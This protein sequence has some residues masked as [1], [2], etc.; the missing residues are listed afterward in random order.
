MVTMTRV[1]FPEN[2]PDEAILYSV[3]VAR[4]D[5][6]WVF[7]RHSKRTTLECPGGHR[8][9]GET[10]DDC[11]RRELW[12]ETGASDYRLDRICAYGVECTKRD[13][14]VEVSF[15]MLYRAEIHA[16]EPIPECSEIA[17]ICLCDSLPENWTYPQIQPHLLRQAWPE[18][19]ADA[20]S[21]KKELPATHLT[22]A[23]VMD[24]NG[25]IFRDEDAP[26]L[27]QLNFSFALVANGIVNGVHWQNIDAY[28]SFVARHPHILPVV[29]VGGWG[30][31]G[32]SQAAATAEGRSLFVASTLELMQ[33]HGFWGV[34][35]D[36]EYPCC[37]MAGIAASPN[38]RENFT[39]L[40][41]ELR[42]G[43]DRL[44]AQDGRKRLLACAL[45]A[46][47]SL[48]ENIDCVAIGQLA[49][50]INL[51]TYDLYSGGVCCHHTALYAGSSDYPLCADLA[52]KTYTEAGIP[53]ERIMVGCAM[54]ARLYE[55]ADGQPPRPFAPSPDNGSRTVPYRVFKKDPDCTMLF[56]EAAQAAYAVCGGSY[57]TCDSE[58]SIAAKRAYVQQNGLMGLMCWEYGSD[59]EGQLLRAMHG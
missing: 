53:A 38:D 9:A 17:E 20:C 23:Y 46:S 40:M 19:S 15:G 35:I 14:R 42:Q 4:M 24:R 51:M 32:F 47:P 5:G 30:A 1:F 59:L 37:D 39:L 34:D 13:G 7:C 45:G 16:L 58:R 25:L 22:A 48:V 2:V 33:K 55:A 52:V 21:K 28:K 49:D 8:E 41:Q 36:W 54:Y 31:D 43:L 11:A 29:S 57:L 26:Y 50:Q 44:T 56:D 27:H 18:C 12:E 3:I 10:P 6:K